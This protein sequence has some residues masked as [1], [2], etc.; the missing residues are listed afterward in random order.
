MSK[1]IIARHKGL[2]VLQHFD[3]FSLED[4]GFERQTLPFL[5]SFSIL[6]IGERKRNRNKTC[7]SKEASSR[8]IQRRKQQTWAVQ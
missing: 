5:S 1:G 3:F 7:L 2:E 6:A 4:L 8:E